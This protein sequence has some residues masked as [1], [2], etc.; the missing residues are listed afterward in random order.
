MNAITKRIVNAYRRGCMPHISSGTP[1]EIQAYRLAEQAWDR[2]YS[3]HGGDSVSI[4]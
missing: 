2:H 4:L 3:R 1:E